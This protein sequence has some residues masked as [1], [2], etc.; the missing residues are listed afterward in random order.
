[1]TRRK[2]P[3][4]HRAVARARRAELPGRQHVDLVILC[5]RRHPLVTFFRD[6]FPGGIDIGYRQTDNSTISGYWPGGDP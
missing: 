6:T 1:M 3:A 2:P 4:R 5:Q